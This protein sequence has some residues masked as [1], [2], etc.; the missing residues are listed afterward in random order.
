MTQAAQRQKRIFDLL[1]AILG[2]L[3]FG[4]LILLLALIAFFDTGKS[5]FFYQTRIGKKA[6]PF[7]IIKIRS[8][9]S[10]KKAENISFPHHHHI[11]L[12]GKFLRKTKLDE[13]PQL[14]NVLVGEMSLVGPRP[15][16]PGFADKLK[17]NDRQLLTLRPGLTGPATLKFRNEDAILATQPDPET[18]NREILWPEKVRINLQYLHN[19]SFQTDLQILFTTLFG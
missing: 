5:G 4:W 16:L 6:V 18:Y 12:Y 8:L 14:W 10:Q 2:L 19:Y 3:V 7:Q 15:D 1:I 9:K 13:L 11:S 17:G